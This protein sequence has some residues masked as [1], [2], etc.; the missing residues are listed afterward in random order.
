MSQLLL[1]AAEV[2]PAGGATTGQIALATGGGLLLTAGLLVTGVAHRRGRIGF[3]GRAGQRASRLLGLPGWAALPA[4]VATASLLLALV[5]M[6]WDIALHIGEGRDA[7]PLTNPAHYLIMG[8]L[9]GI[10]A[11]GCLGVILATGRVSA[12]AV[13]ISE[14]W[15]APLG[16]LLMVACAGFALSGFPLDDVWH[17]A[18]GQDVT[19]WGPTHLM[20]VGGSMLSLVGLAVLLTEGARAS[21][22]P[23]RLEGLRRAAVCGGLLVALTSLAAEFEFGV[24]QF[25][26]LFHPLLVLFAA[27]V[28]LVAAR[29]WGGRGSALAAVAF[30]LVMRALTSLLVG[31]VLGE[32]TPHFP[33]LIAEAVVVELVALRVARGRPIALGL[34]AGLGVGTV[35]LASEWAWSQVWMPLPWTPSLLPEG[36]LVGL[37]AALAGGV[38]GALTGA[39]LGPEGL[40]SPTR[41]LK[42]APV[43]ALLAVAGLAGYGLR[44][45]PE[46]GLTAA[47]ALEAVEPGRTAHARV[48]F[49]PTTAADDAEWVTVT[50]WQGGG[51]VVDRLEK[52]EAGVYRTTE[53]VPLHG[54]WKALVRVHRG[55]SLAGVPLYLPEDTAIPAPAVAAPPRVERPLVNDRSILQREQTGDG[56]P[57]LSATLPIVVLAVSATLLALLAWG[58]G[59]VGRPAQSPSDFPSISRMISSVPPPMGPSRASRTARSI[60]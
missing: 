21:E 44:T 33:L 57:W 43:A 42:L 52:V 37:A 41:A 26:L 32:T 22:A 13:R 53:P 59:R 11:A 34:W 16:A 38:L 14:G 47:V 19:L 24:P 54:N 23:P 18:F 49:E 4:V 45:E 8:G 17:R 6:Y 20:L 55:N 5:G 48:S 31:P 3:L 27:S 40:P 25:R 12:A 7:G 29:A 1:L 60:S 28:G 36:A 9:F 15:H 50:A 35:G 58:L 46:R 39:A 30:Y 56:E 2:K 10:F 51:L